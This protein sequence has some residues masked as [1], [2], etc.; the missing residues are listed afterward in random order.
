MPYKPM[1]TPVPEFQHYQN[2]FTAHIRDPKEQARPHG[3]EARRMKVYNE[4]VYNSIEGALANC[5]P[6]L[7][8]VLGKRRWVQLMRAFLA[9]HRCHSPFFYQ[10]PD[11]LIQFLQAEWTVSQD[12]PVFM[13]ELAHYE[14]VELSLSISTKTPDWTQIDASGDLLKQQPVLN[15][16]LANLYY[17]WP[18]HLIAPRRKVAP[19]DTFLLVFRNKDDQIQ[20]IEIN[21]FTARLLN[22]LETTNYTGQTA[23]EMIAQ[24]SRH[25]VPEVVIEGGLAVMQD[26]HLR[27]GLL[28]V[29]REEHSL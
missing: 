27:G 7:K 25:S 23:L 15:P 28:G 11:E 29:M 13:L 19:K 16:V 26:L 5:F 2:S 4:L 17:R 21:A 24:E 14:W 9:K 3:I 1:P 8:K 10:I 20:F 12:Y 22:L 18:V 6:V